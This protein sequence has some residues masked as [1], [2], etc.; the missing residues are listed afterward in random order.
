MLV[1]LD[2]SGHPR[3]TDNNIYSCLVAVCIEE[4][5]I[6]FM[7]RDI[8]MLKN[9][10][11]GDQR[12]IKASS[13]LHKRTFIRPMNYSKCKQYIDEVVNLFG[14]YNV[15][16]FAV[17]VERPT[18]DILPQDGFLPK[19]YIPI[20]KIVERFCER[21]NK[22]K[23]LFIYDVQELKEDERRALAFT[24][25]LYKS[26]LGRTFNKIL[27]VPLFASSS[28]TAGIQLADVAASII[29]L[30]YTYGLD[31]RSPETGL[32]LWVSK[33]FSI[34]KL[35]TETI[36]E[37]NTGFLHHGFYKMPRAVYEG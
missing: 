25:F 29:R 6:R 16:T 19:H 24:N 7:M 17:I 33:L 18:I 31:L 23:S 27:E 14:Q 35:T 5:D 26:S 13:V 21:E 32:E 37:E 3:P 34:L 30:N 11:F 28:C 1:F 8:Y 20:I 15:K 10:L 12:E 4:T 2:E 36:R 22:L 9:A